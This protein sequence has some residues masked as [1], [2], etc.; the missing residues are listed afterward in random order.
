MLTKH[1]EA[2]GKGSILDDPA[3][4][5][6]NRTWNGAYGCSEGGRLHAGRMPY[7]TELMTVTTSEQRAASCAC[8]GGTTHMR[9]HTE[10]PMPT[11]TRLL[12]PSIQRLV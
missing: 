5:K 2:A 1:T 3:T 9:V 7:S 4:G 12:W 11:S 8:R 10:N 6:G